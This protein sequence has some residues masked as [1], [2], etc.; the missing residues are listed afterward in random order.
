MIRG[1][2]ESASRNNVS[3]WLYSKAFNLHGQ[4]LLAFVGK[5]H[6]G[7]GRVELFRKDILDAGLG[8][9]YSG[10]YF[11]VDL[12]P[13]EHPESIAIRLEA[14]DLSL[15]HPASIVVPAER[16]PA[17]LPTR[18]LGGIPA[19]RPMAVAAGQSSRA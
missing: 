18:T 9:G 14:S 13:S 3:G 10:F 8:D 1:A 19:D 12:R 4:L 7:S 11:P 15:L 2:L 5:R 16:A 6:V 17:R